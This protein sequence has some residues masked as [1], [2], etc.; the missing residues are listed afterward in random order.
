MAKRHF[1]CAGILAACA[2]L[3][4]AVLATLHY[5]AGVTK[6]NYDRI[7]EGMTLA[8]VQE[9]FGKEGAVFHGF[10]NKTAYCWENEDR[11]YAILLFNDN[12]KDGGN[13]LLSGCLPRKFAR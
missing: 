5:R 2:A 6:A 3:V 1:I 11:S 8:E 4:L 12:R 7:E 10:A 9:I 13:D